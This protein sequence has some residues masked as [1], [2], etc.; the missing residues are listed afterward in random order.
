MGDII[1]SDNVVGKLIGGMNVVLSAKTVVGEPV[2]VGKTY[3]I[4]L[5]D[6]NFGLAASSDTGSSKNKGAGGIGGKM[7]PSAILVIQE[8]GTTRLLSVKNQDSITKIMDMIPE[9]VHRLSKEKKGSL[10][11]DEI[12]DIA[13]PDEDL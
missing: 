10:S 3:I 1:K 8:D 13:F 6:V 11:D 9:V 2:C 4:P 12:A 5:V 7:T